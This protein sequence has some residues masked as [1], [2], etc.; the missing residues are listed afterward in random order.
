MSLEN[1]TIIGE[2]IN[3]GFKSTKELFDNDDLEAIQALAVKQ[4]DAG[5]AYLNVNAGVR[6]KN[7]P[8]FVRDI[9]HAIQDVVDIP[10]SFDFPNVEVQVNCLET[11]DQER[12]GG[13]KPIIN[14]ISEPRRDMME[15]LKVRPCRVVIMSS[16]RLEGGKPKPNVTSG[17]M[18]TTAKRLAGAMQDDHGMEIGDLFIDVAIGTMSSDMQ[19][20]TRAAI[21]TTKLVSDEPD[22]AGIHMWG[23]LSNLSAQ[24]PAAKIN[25]ESL[26]LLLENIFLTLAMPNGFD[27]VLGTPWR[28]YAFVAEGHPVMGDFKEII[29]LNGSDA[30]RRMRKMYTS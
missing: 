30:L 25:G 8:Q 4:R 22:L 20:A 23:G 3:P 26:K 28:D 9:I 7:D 10:L 17:E 2:R 21:E 24:M 16:E 12:G 5:A 14:S 15:L 13:M 11:Y 18:L 19:G 6:A 27:T 29:A 1:L